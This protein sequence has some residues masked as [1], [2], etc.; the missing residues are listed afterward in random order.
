MARR[1][2]AALT[3]FVVLAVSAVMYAVPATPEPGRPTLLATLNATLNG[4]SACALLLGYYFIRRGER[5][6]HRVC[7]LAATLVSAVFLV[8]YLIHHSQVGS[9][10]Y[11]GQGLLRVVYFLLLVPHVVLAAGILPMALMTL[12]RGHTQRLAAHRKLA[13]WTLPLWLYVSVSGVGVYFMLYFT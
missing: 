6:A 9:V 10:H 13:R 7:M 1:V 3:V 12:Y 2:V 5:A 4:L 8:T 11:G